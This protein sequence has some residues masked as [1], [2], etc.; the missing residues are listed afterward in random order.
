M[1]INKNRNGV[2]YQRAPK[3]KMRRIPLKKINKQ[4][5]KQIITGESGF[6]ALIS[7]ILDKYQILTNGISLKEYQIK[8][9]CTAERIK[10]L[11]D[12]HHEPTNLCN[13]GKQA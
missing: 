6:N 2:K 12:P 10:Q 8:I 7:G 13:W 5:S 1:Q 9:F 11:H 4:K 3:I